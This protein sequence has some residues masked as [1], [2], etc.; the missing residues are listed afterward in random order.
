MEITYIYDS[1]K[2][3]FHFT[4]EIPSPVI[5]PTAAIPPVGRLDSSIH[6][7]LQYAASTVSSVVREPSAYPQ[8]SSP[9]E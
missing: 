8:P 6:L 7:P 3:G 9:T 2:E 1:F 4:L 5:L